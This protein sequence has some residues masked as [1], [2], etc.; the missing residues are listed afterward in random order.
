MQSEFL[1]RKDMKSI[2]DSVTALPERR[3][4]DDIKKTYPDEWICINLKNQTIEVCH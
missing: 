1:N 3:S 4:I 2:E